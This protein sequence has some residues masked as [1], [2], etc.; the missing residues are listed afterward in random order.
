MLYRLNCVVLV[1]LFISINAKASGADISTRIIGGSVA[2]INDY[3]YFVSLMNAYPEYSDDYYPFCGA[4][5]LGDGLIVTAAHC[6]YDRDWEGK[7]SIYVTVGNQSSYMNHVYVNDGEYDYLEYSGDTHEVTSTDVIIHPFY[8]E[9]NLYTYAYDVAIIE[10]DENDS[11]LTWPTTTLGLPATDVF[12]NLAAN[13]YSVTII[14]HGT[15]EYSYNYIDQEYVSSVVSADLLEVDI[16]ARTDSVC[17][18]AN[19]SQFREYSM[20]CAGDHGED[21]CQGDSGGPLIYQA[22]NTLLGIT[23][24]GYGCGLDGYYGIYTNV[25]NMVDWIESRGTLGESQLND[26]DVVSSSSS[27]S[28]SGSLGFGILFASVGL[29]LC[30]KK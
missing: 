22:D 7:G 30:R 12:S 2:N 28:S 10:I 11:L 19:G 3:E 29:L 16:T 18:D 21:A 17:S 1:I 5:Y 8:N 24:W 23:S 27:N 9:D 26:V 14:G 6:V 20:I 15:T 4:S 13:D 25:Y